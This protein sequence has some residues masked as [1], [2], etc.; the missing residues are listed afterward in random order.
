M[1]LRDVAAKALRL[2]ELAATVLADEHRQGWL[3]L[4]GMRELL[5]IQQL[6]IIKSAFVGLG[7]YLWTEIRNRGSKADF[8]LGF[9][10]FLRVAGSWRIVEVGGQ[11]AG[12]DV[13]QVKT[14]LRLLR[15]FLL[16]LWSDFDLRRGR[17]HED[18]ASRPLMLVEELRHILGQGVRLVTD[19]KVVKPV[20]HFVVIIHLG[21]FQ[22]VLVFVRLLRALVCEEAKAMVVYANRFVVADCWQIKIYRLFF[23]LIE[24]I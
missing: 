10:M 17:L 23:Q 14:P 21:P 19:K 24:R 5:C 1:L 22:V 13:V 8:L 3:L 4:G 7:D 6:A 18:F 15:L 12:C 9:F 16:G 20:R 11:V 2:V